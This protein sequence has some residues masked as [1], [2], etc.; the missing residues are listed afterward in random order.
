MLFSFHLFF[1]VFFLVLS[2]IEGQVYVVPVI[3]HAHYYFLCTRRRPAQPMSVQILIPRELQSFVVMTWTELH[4]CGVVYYCFCAR[5]IRS[6]VVSTSTALFRVH[7][8][9]CISVRLNNQNG[10]WLS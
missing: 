3:L 7:L 6:N 8:R 10:P 2:F 9:T 1:F 5:R 4:A